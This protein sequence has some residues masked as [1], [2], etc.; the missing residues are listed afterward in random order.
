MQKQLLKKF[1]FHWDLARCG[2]FLL[3]CAMYV[4]TYLFTYLTEHIHYGDVEHSRR[5]HDALTRH[6]RSAADHVPNIDI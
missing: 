1:L 6:V 2:N 3:K 5:R 4:Y